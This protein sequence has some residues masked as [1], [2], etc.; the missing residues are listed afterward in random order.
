MSTEVRRT[1]N[2]EQMRKNFQERDD[3]MRELARGKAPTQAAVVQA[4]EK[5]KRPK[6]EKSVKADPKDPAPATLSPAREE[7]KSGKELMQIKL[8]HLEK[9]ATHPGILPG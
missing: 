1:V 3:L 8:E 9:A 2:L 6:R 7:G 4:E 5:P